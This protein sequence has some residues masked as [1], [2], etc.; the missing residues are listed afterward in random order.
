MVSKKIIFLGSKPV[1]YDCLSFLIDQRDALNIEITGVLTHSRKEFGNT[2]DLIQLAEENGLPII[3]EPSEMAD[4]DIIYSVQYHKIL[5]KEQIEK[6]RQVAVNLHMAPLPE[7]RGSN[8][9]T[10]AIIDQK[11]EFGTTIHIMDPKID[12][13]DIIY[14]KR[15]AIPENCWVNQL[16]QMTYEASLGLFCQ[17]LPLLLK[18]DY[19][20]IPQQ[21]MVEQYG[22]SLHYRK[23]INDIKQIDLNWD[24]EKIERY[25]RAT[26]MPG[27]AP[28]FCL[29][30]GKKVILNLAEN[31]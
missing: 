15:F 9:F 3:N 24:T 1:G 29:V 18:G 5:L 28:P 16:Y 25:I 2:H 4:C 30:N 31:G 12:N 10:N 26:S 6:A 21:S 23:E 13:G 11:K 17:T 27:F 22:T 19:V 7:Y 14:Q 8:Q 20:Q